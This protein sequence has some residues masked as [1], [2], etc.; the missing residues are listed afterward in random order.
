MIRAFE[1]ENKRVSGFF[2]SGK[3]IRTAMNG[4]FL[5][6]YRSKVTRQAV[7]WLV[8]TARN[9]CSYR[10]FFCFYP[11][12]ASVLLATSFKRLFLSFQFLSFSWFQGS[13]QKSKR[14]VLGVR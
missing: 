11:Y 7:V 14:S 3:G 12:P 10:M 8:L 2:L 4:G 6:N 5:L 9:C 1:E 13:F